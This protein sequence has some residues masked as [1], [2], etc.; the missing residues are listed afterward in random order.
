MKIIAKNSISNNNNRPAELQKAKIRNRT[1]CTG[2]L[3]PITIIDEIKV[4]PAKK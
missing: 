1:E 4:R 3:D 2:F